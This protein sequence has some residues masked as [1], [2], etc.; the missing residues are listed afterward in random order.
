M[1]KSKYEVC[2]QI[3]SGWSG[4]VKYPDIPL[5]VWWTPF[6]G[7]EGVQQ[8]GDYQ[9]YV[10]NDRK[11]RPHPNLRTFFFY[12]TDFNLFSDLASIRKHHS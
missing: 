2:C 10:T 7:D 9:C 1:L 3:S 11:Y 8:C 4:P 6:T 5:M 12:G